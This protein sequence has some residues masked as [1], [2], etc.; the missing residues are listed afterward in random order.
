MEKSTSPDFT[1]WDVGYVSL[2]LYAHRK[3]GL[4]WASENYNHCYTME[5]FPY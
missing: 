4:F 5:N 1:V 3:Y 2:Q